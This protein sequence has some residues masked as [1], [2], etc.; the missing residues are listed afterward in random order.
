MTYRERLTCWAVV[1]LLPN[2]QRIVVARFRSRSDADGHLQVL[3]RMLPMAQFR[4]VFDLEED[5]GGMRDE[6][7]FGLEAALAR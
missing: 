7:K 3:Q 4:V 2:M 6:E 5:S 1:R